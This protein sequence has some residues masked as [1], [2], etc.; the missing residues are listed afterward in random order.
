M[1]KIGILIGSLSQ[2]SYSR[3]IAQ[4]IVNS[5]PNITF[6]ELNYRQL[7]L[8]DPD[9]E[10]NNCPINWQ[11]F[12]LAIRKFN[13]LL[14]VT[15]EYNYSIPGGLKNALDILSG[16]D[17]RDLLMDKPTMIITDSSG[18]RGGLIANLQLQQVLRMLGMR[19]FN[20]EVTFSN[21]QELFN[22]RDELIDQSSRDFLITNVTQFYDFIK[23]TE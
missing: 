10:V 18:N 9:L 22:D 12:R 6:I 13:A 23:R 20:N 1:I 21:V 14:F 16:S 11:A 15:P 2:K 8:Y 19:V 3:K 7:S 17:T 5:F 4:F